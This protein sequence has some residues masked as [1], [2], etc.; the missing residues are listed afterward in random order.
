MTK[1]GVTAACFLDDEVAGFTMTEMM[2]QG[3]RIPGDISVTGF[4]GM[5]F[6]A[7]LAVPLTTLSVPVRAMVDRVQ[8]ILRRDPARHR[9]CFPLTIV[10]RASHGPVRAGGRPGGGDAP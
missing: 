8:H 4:D 10:E 7:A 5:P 3:I 9:H 1:Q 6:A 2:R